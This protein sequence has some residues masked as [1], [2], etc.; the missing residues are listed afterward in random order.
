M[1][2][3]A[4]P[5]RILGRTG[6]AVSCL[7]LG[8]TEIGYVYGIGPRTLPSE[9]EAIELVRQSVDLGITFIDTA[10]FYGEAEERIGKSGV[11]KLPGVVVAT[12]CGHVLDRGESFTAEEFEWQVRSEVEE[13][14]RKLKL[15]VLSL[16]LYHGGSPEQ[17]RSGLLVEVVQKLKDE[18]KVRFAGI[19]TRGEESPLAAIETG[20]F[21]VIQVGH[22]ILDQRLVARI[23]SLAEKRNIGV[24][25]RSVLLKGALTGARRHLPDE[26]APLKANADRAEAIGRG[27]GVDLPTLAI[28]F[29]LSNPAISIVLVGTNKLEHLKRARNAALAGPLPADVLVELR[30]LAIDDY[31]QVDPKY[32]PADSVSDAK[33][34]L[35]VHG[36]PAG[37]PAERNR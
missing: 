32:W 30:G 37:A 33:G 12:K 24:M 11:A 21:D 6:L 15:D 25:N 7:G 29:A 5:T 10:H 34:G 4:L 8:T 19:S 23:L 20:F 26:L 35:K 1:V 9:D 31:R 2:E 16:V 18:G 14:L 17:I 36:V 27:F 13:S 28:R 3:H 22:S